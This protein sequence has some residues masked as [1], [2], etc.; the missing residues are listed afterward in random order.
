MT[1]LPPSQLRRKLILC[2]MSTAASSWLSGCCLFTHAPLP[3]CIAA[4]PIPPE[5]STESELTIDVHAHFFNGTDLQ[6]KDFIHKNVDLHFPV[7]L[8]SLAGA[9]VKDLSWNVAPKGDEEFKELQALAKCQGDAALRSSMSAHKQAS[10]ANALTA[11]SKTAVYRK[12]TATPEPAKAAHRAVYGSPVVTPE[13]LA[14]RFGDFVTIKLSEQPNAAVPASRAASA[15]AA[16]AIKASEDT[17]AVDRYLE[18][19]IQ[20]FQYRYVNIQDYT[21]PGE[22]ASTIPVPAPK[23]TVD[24]MIANL[25]D[26]DWPLAEGRI[27]PTPIRD[28][29]KVMEQISVM[30]HGQVHAF[31]PYCPMRQVAMKAKKR[32]RGLHSTEGSDLTLEEMKN[33]IKTRGFIG[34]KLYPPMGFMPKGNADQND[35]LI[36][37]KSGLPKWMNDKVH[38]PTDGARE[39]STATFGQ[40]LDDELNE[41]YAWASDNDVPI[42]AHAEPTNGPSVAFENFDLAAGWIAARGKHKKLRI[43]FGHSGGFSDDIVATSICPSPVPDNSKALFASF[44]AKP[45]SLGEHAYAD[46][47][48]SDGILHSPD[49]FKCRLSTAIQSYPNAA[50]RLMYGTDWFMTIQEPSVQTY[51]SRF[52]TLLSELDSDHK[53]ISGPALSQRI[54]AQNAVEWLGLASGEQTRIRLETFYKANGFDLANNRPEWMKKVDAIH[55]T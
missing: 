13:A 53:E 7:F 20:G 8:K 6:V 10:I 21:S 18:F 46:L 44:G 32:G 9:I 51:Q 38:Y 54:F 3:T 5:P 24:L 37:V 33:F 11:L 19:I 1:A 17:T 47:S 42:T 40:R 49:A 28:Q 2:A 36:W 35:Q 26:Y 43:N 12:Y 15:R 27:T 29:L 25:V 45:G 52:E 50:Y 22:V 4:P 16:T 23:R 34:F 14:T 31:L 55:K 41:L 30:K 48:Y 39:A